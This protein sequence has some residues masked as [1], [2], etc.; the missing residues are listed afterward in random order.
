VQPGKIVDES[1]PFFYLCDFLVSK[2]TLLSCGGLFLISFALFSLITPN[3]LINGDAALYQ[4]QITHFDFSQRTIHLGYYLLGIPFIHFLPLP[5][6]YALNLMNCF[7][8]AL[9]IVLIFTI[10]LTVSQNLL[11]AFVS[12]TLLLTNYIFVYNGV[13]AEVYMPQL[14]FFLLSFQLVLLQKAIPAGIAFALAFL[15]TPSSLFGFPCLILLL[16]GK[17]QLF[18]FS[19][20]AFLVI[21]VPIAPHRTDYFLGGRGLLKA[22][23]DQISIHHV[24]IK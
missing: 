20:A 15:I 12:S 19:A 1:S 13:Y 4:Q 3:A 16:R 17:K 11:V 24:L 6:D 18:H 21:S 7:L 9:S 14:F 5:A 10:A 2:K 8:G 22:V 23:Q